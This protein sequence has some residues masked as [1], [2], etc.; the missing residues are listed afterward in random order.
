LLICYDGS[1]GAKAAL[2]AAAQAFAGHHAVVACYWQP[3][4]TSSKRFGLDLRELV[5]ESDDINRREAELARTL[6]DEGAALA[7]DAGL[8]AEARAVEIDGPIDEAILSHADELDAAAIV[9]GSRSRSSV[10]SLLLGSIANEIVQRAPRPVYLAPSV[11][12]AGRR[13]N[14]LAG[15]NEEAAS[16][17]E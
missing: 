14:Q 5:Q 4:A 9:L 12:L 16:S 11:S 7:R 10:R 15:E 1:D 13:R 3:L 17:T 8:E 6:A 2:A